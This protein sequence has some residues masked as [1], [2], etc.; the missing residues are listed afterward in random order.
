MGYNH[1]DH[2]VK[3]RNTYDYYVKNCQ[4]GPCFRFHCIEGFFHE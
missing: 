1:F 2:I 3:G 4:I